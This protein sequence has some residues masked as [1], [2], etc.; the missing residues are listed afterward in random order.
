MQEVSGGCYCGNIRIQASFS[1]D[2][3]SY[4]PRACDCD[5]CRKHAAAYV[6]D[7]K[8]SLRLQIGNDLEVNRFR[9]GS[10]TAEMLLCR[11]CGVM[12]GALYRESHRLFGTLN[13]KALD[14][15]LSFGHEQGV[16]PKSLSPDQKVRRWHELWFPD[17]LLNIEVSS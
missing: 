7:P 12:V 15:R 1:R 10:N 9:Q 14:S 5:F 4:N 16:S 11:T 8:G 6:S 2:L 13:V 17:V 3:A